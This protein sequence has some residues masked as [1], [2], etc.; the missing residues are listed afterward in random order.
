VLDTVTVHFIDMLNLH[1]GKPKK[2]QYY[3]KSVAKTGTAYDTVN[4]NMT[5]K[6]GVNVQILNSYASPLVNE[7]SILTSNSWIV[8]RKNE[9]IIYHPR[10]TFDKKGFFKDPPIYKKLKIKKDDDYHKSLS[11]SLDDFIFHIKN[12]IPFDLK[13]F[14]TS[15][16]VNKIIID[17]KNKRI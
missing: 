16:E 3:P 2:I 12:N 17:L 15:L 1:F 7:I 6:N 8:F 14:N 11:C 9:F 10:N 5:Y 4:V 13:F